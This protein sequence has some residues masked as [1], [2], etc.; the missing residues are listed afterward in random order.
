MTIRT[1]LSFAAALL[2]LAVAPAAFGQATRTWVSGVGD[3]ANPCSRTAPCKTF[4][5]A[6]SKTAAGGEISVLDPG[7]FGAVTITKSITISG[8]GTLAGILSAGTNG[9]II[10]AGVN[11]RVVLRNLSIHGAGTGLNGIRY[12]A[13][14]R[15]ELDRV[16]ISSV[17]TRAIDISLSA[18]GTIVGRDVSIVGAPAG[19]RIATTAGF[20]TGVFDRLSI[21][22]ATTGVEATANTFVSISDSTVNSGGTALLSSASTSLLIAE[23]STLAFN[24]TAVSASVSGATV[25]LANNGIYNNTVGISFVAGAQVRSAGNNRVDGNP[26]STAPNFAIPLQ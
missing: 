16:T 2:S 17:T 26:T 21:F 11:D 9:V 8:D 24:G 15:V 20:A 4:A 19:I 3:D 22:G 7:G 12:L 14:G 18:S 13:G 23:G 5:G 25:R 10:N 6:I 1:R